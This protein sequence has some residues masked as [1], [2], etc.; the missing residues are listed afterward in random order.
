VKIKMSETHVIDGKGRKTFGVGREGTTL[1]EVAKQEKYRQKREEMKN[2]NKKILE[3]VGITNPTQTE[4]ESN[5]KEVVAKKLL[6]PIFDS[7][8]IRNTNLEL[9]EKLKNFKYKDIF[10]RFPESEKLINLENEGIK[11]IDNTMKWLLA[12]FGNLKD[13]EKFFPQYPL[14]AFLLKKN[15]I[16][17]S[18]T[19]C[20]MKMEK[21]L[22]KKGLIEK[23]G[24]NSKVTTYYNWGNEKLEKYIQN[25][26][27]KSKS[28]EPKEA[29]VEKTASAAS[30]ATTAGKEEKKEEKINTDSHI[31][32][33]SSISIGPDGITLKIEMEG[34]TKLNKNIEQLIEEMKNS[35]KFFKEF[36]EK[37]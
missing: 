20:R 14:K 10:A 27:E 16:P 3:R 23:A 34:I 33:H 18:P 5:P 12:K 19:T 29:K 4:L 28:T 7:K 25:Q 36:S 24:F 2:R 26:K 32:T 1:D 22:T 17:I 37:F 8:R 35:T 11:L 15:G 31:N 21:L 9:T 6:K 30:V 13:K